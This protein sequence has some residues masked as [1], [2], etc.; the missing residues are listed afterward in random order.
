MWTGLLAKIKYVVG[1][2]LALIMAR[3]YS[4]MMSMSWIL[5]FQLC[6][7]L[8]P[9]RAALVF[10]HL[11]LMMGESDHSS[12]SQ[13]VSVVAS[14]C[15]KIMS[16]ALRITLSQLNPGESWCLSLGI[17][18]WNLGNEHCKERKWEPSHLFCSSSQLASFLGVDN[19]AELRPPYQWKALAYLLY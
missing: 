2:P 12:A 4:R 11:I 13:R 16:H 14:P 17:F 15:L 6:Q 10:Y 8:F 1:A 7:C 18:F 9:S 19:V 3:T 5:S